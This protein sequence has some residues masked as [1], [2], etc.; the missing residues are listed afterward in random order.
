MGI[1]LRKVMETDL[2]P[3]RPLVARQRIEDVPESWRL[4]LKMLHIEVREQGKRAKSPK[5]WGMAVAILLLAC[6]G[7]CEDESLVDPVEA[8]ETSG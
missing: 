1:E 6:C 5:R 7:R 8:G 2:G 4:A 3:Y